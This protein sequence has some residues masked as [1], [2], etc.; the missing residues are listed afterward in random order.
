MEKPQ[1]SVADLMHATT[2]SAALG[3]AVDKHLTLFLKTQCYKITAGVYGPLPSGTVEMVSGRSSV[4]SPEIVVHPGI[5]DEEF[6]GE[7]KIMAYVKKKKKKK[8]QFNTGDR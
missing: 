7:M 3:V 5:I 8:M 1:L 6:K 4:T 2:G